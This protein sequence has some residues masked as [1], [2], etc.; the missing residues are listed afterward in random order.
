MN[1][2]YEEGGLRLFH[3]DEVVILS[4]FAEV[5]L[6]VDQAIKH[7]SEAHRHCSTRA[8]ST[9]AKVRLLAVG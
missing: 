3:N 4:R 2:E 9:G 5:Q 7:R 6:F 8:R 1:P